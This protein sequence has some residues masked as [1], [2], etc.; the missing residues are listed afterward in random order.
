MKNDLIQRAIG[1]LDDD[2]VES[3]DRKPTVILRAPRF[4]RSA[5]AAVFAL[6][7]A[8]AAL[9]AL[10]QQSGNAPVT[11]GAEAGPGQSVG[12]NESAA[13]D[14][15]FGEDVLANDSVVWASN[16][17]FQTD[18]EGFS[19][20]NGK[21]VAMGLVAALDGADDDTVFAILGRAPFAEDFV[22]NGKTLAEYYAAMANESILPETLGQLRKDG[23]ALKYGKALYETGTPEG[24]KWAQ[25]LYEERVAFYGEELLNRYIVDGEFLEEKLQN[26]QREALGKTE[27]HDA[28][29]EARS[30]YLAA[31][32]DSIPGEYPSQAAPGEGGVIF[33]LTKAAF[34]AYTREDIRGWTF[35]SAAK[36]TLFG[37]D[38]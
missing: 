13:A 12:E 24:E 7:A 22:F 3:A 25:S 30:A 6:A 20:W 28:Y 27:A 11:P 34:A 21:T 26:D 18:D 38:E 5:V 35:S 8:G 15:R 32:A 4:R 33:Y 1:A 10:L 29:E 23:G 14:P 16:G 9:F 19:E 37:E 36:D 17:V 2:L 31:L